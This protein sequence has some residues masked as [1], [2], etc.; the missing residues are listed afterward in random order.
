MVHTGWRGAFKV[1]GGFGLIVAVSGYIIMKEPERDS[2]NNADEERKFEV[3]D[4]ISYITR[5]YDVDSVAQIY[6]EG[7]EGLK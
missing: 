7:E 1:C 3:P 5:T 2:I 6:G 4:H